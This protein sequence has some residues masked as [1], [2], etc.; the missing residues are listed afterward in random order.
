MDAKVLAASLA[1]LSSSLDDAVAD[2][3]LL[4]GDGSDADDGAFA[5]ARARE[6]ESSY[7]KLLAALSG[8]GISSL[9]SPLNQVSSTLIMWTSWS[10]T[11]PCE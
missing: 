3:E 7:A 10:R 4:L 11:E 8:A 1:L 5:K 6:V 2:L 9:R